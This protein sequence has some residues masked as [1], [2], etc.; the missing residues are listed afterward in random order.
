[1]HMKKN[2]CRIKIFICAQGPLNIPKLDPVLHDPKSNDLCDKGRLISETFFAIFLTF[3]MK[4][5]CPSSNVDPPYCTVY[6]IMNPT[7][8]AR[9]LHII[10]HPPP[11]CLFDTLF[12]R[13]CPFKILR[14]FMQNT[15]F[16]IM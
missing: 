4:D 16:S 2:Y 14:F 7:Y 8:C 15:K 3:F 1:M 9:F 6:V 12:S 10:R 13:Q 11:I 5:F